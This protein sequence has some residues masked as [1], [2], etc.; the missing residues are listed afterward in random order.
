MQL[1]KNGAS[2]KS[3]PQSYRPGNQEFTA[4]PG[5]VW[6]TLDLDIIK[7]CDP[8]EPLRRLPPGPMKKSQGAL[9]SGRFFGAPI[10]FFAIRCEQKRGEMF[11]SGKSMVVLSSASVL[12][13]TTVADNAGDKK[14]RCYPRQFAVL[15]SH[16][17]ASESEFNVKTLPSS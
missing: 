7:G 12:S 4:R 17:D 14:Y 10:T 3:S 8:P 6:K 16:P 1:S 15:T 5:N 11:V 13:V 2:L 9:E